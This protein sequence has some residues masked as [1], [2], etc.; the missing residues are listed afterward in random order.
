[1]KLTL[2]IPAIIAT[3]LLG[4]VLALPGPMPV[5]EPESD[6]AAR[7]GVVTIPGVRYTKRVA[8]LSANTLLLLKMCTSGTQRCYITVRGQR[9]DYPCNEGRVREI[10]THCLVV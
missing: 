3:F 7:Q 2:S 10:A 5:A 9:T 1:M 4:A 8:G 6:I